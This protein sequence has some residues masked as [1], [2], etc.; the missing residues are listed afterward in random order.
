MKRDGRT[1]AERLR[2]ARGKTN[3]SQGD[4]AKAVD[5]SQ[6]NYCDLEQGNQSGSVKIVEIAD[7]LRVSP[8]WLAMGIVDENDTPLYSEIEQEL[9]SIFRA[10]R[11]FKK[12]LMNKLIDWRES[13]S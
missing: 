2:E 3:L 1:L 13:Q 5:M 7:V 8:R 4:V 12:D 10:N 6:P 11:K 9:V